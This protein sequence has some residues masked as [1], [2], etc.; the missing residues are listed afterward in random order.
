ML[1][2][3]GDC[4]AGGAG[5]SSAGQERNGC[6]SRNWHLAEAAEITANAVCNCLSWNNQTPSIR[7]ISKQATPIRIPVRYFLYVPAEPVVPK[8]CQKIQQ[9]LHSF[10][11]VMFKHQKTHIQH[12]ELTFDLHIL[13]SER[14]AVLKDHT[15]KTDGSVSFEGRSILK[16]SQSLPRKTLAGLKG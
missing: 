9:E 7:D 8:E 3:I 6:S 14:K 12:T 16:Y 1:E 13:K 11:V 10:V 5:F 2:I 15:G 4:A